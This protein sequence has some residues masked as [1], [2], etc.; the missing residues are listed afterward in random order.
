MKFKVLAGLVAAAASLM[1]GQAQAGAVGIANMNVTALG[2]AAPNAPTINITN[3]SRTGTAA[4][5]YNGNP[6]TGV[7][8]NSITK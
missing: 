3:E 1:A 2:F 4:A 5:S 6:A 7:G 8:A